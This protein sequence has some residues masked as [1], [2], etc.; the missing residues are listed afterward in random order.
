[1]T[2]SARR[3]QATAPALCASNVAGVERERM[4]NTSAVCLIKKCLRLDYRSA[5][6]QLPAGGGKLIVGYVF[7]DLNVARC[8][9]SVANILRL[10]VIRPRQSTDFRP[11][12]PCNFG[13]DFRTMGNAPGLEPAVLH[14]G[15]YRCTDMSRRL[16]NAVI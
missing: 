3:I 13:G 9:L 8:F 12:C 4:Q 6:R 5:L 7:D 11:Q 16:R 1:M 2:R 10:R 15:A 14:P